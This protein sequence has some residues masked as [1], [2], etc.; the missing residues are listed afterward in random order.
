MDI[1][2]IDHIKRPL[3]GEA[4]K[5]AM[6]NKIVRKTIVDRLIYEKTCLMISADPGCGKSTI[7]AQMAIELAAGLPVFGCFEVVEPTKV[8]YMQTER[9]ILELLERMQI[10]SK[11]Y[12]I[13]S[14]NL[15]V[16]DNYQLLNLANPRDGELFLDC[17]ERDFNQAKVLIVDPIYATVL[18]GLKDEG[19]ATA[20]NNIMGKAMKR[21]DLA[22]TY[23]HHTIK[24]TYNTKGQPYEKDDPFYGSQW[25]KAHVTGSYHMKKTSTGVVLNKKKDNYE[26]LA[27]KIPLEYDP[28]TGLCSVIGAD[29]NAFDKV[30]NYLMIKKMDKKQFYFKDIQE[31]TELG[32][33]TIRDVLLHSSIKPLLNVVSNHKNRYLYE[34]CTPL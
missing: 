15:M 26:L 22:S 11:H 6:E 29:L 4:L 3:T 27:N 18:G 21:F 17:L 33:R 1:K 20:F 2:R 24:A 5:E 23:S 34:I 28:E 9:D 8:F 13:I 32:T 14:E 10:L 12:P 19:P 30:K 16:T 25:L 31:H 7:M